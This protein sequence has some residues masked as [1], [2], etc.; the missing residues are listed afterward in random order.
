MDHL[1]PTVTDD[2]LLAL[3][4][5]V[6]TVAP[7]PPATASIR[8]QFFRPGFPW[9]ALVDLA[10]AHEVLPPLIFSLNDR[11][12]L[13]PVPA[14][15]DDEGRTAHVTSRLA[16]AYA[17]HLARQADLQDQLIGT[18]AALNA[19]GMVPVLLKGALHLTMPQPSWH[20]SRAMRDI[21][22][23][24]PAEDAARAH[25]LVA[26]LGYQ[27]DPNPP[28][29]DRHLPELVKPGRAG[30]IEIH[31]DALSFAA[32]HALSTAEVWQRAENRSFA[33]VRFKA[34]PP[35]WHVLHGLLHHQLSDRGHARRMLAVKGLWEF[36]RGGAV[37]SSA[38]WN[39]FFAHAEQRGILDMLSSWAV[40]ANRLFGLEAPDMLLEFAAGRRHADATFR[41]ARV[42]YGARQTLFVADKLKFAFAPKTLAL[43]Y[44]ESTAGAAALRHLGFLWRR[45]SQMVRRW[46]GR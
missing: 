44:G 3:L 21:D 14:K 36:A 8:L 12:L 43:R 38:G 46:L 7:T 13:P 18:L 4:G 10:V 22:L 31:T 37:F 5:S 34:L 28:P 30:T 33:G 29:L 16:A 17:E 25:A 9:Q 2:D 27:A 1:P 32:T 6:L 26:S 41:R 42:A 20:G 35:E 11:S 15:L 24:V 19:Q 39:A 45:R 23:L 40:Q